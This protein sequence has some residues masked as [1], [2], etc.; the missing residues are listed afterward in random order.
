MSLFYNGLVY[1]QYC[2][3]SLQDMI[4]IFFQRGVYKI[5][6]LN[7]T[8]AL[9]QMVQLSLIVKQHWMQAKVKSIYL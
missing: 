6:L 5:D 1:S 7:D 9:Q 3:D 4:L 8:I 2:K